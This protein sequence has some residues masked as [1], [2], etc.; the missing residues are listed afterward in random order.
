M[1]GGAVIR[2]RQLWPT[3]D[4][5]A[6]ARAGEID[7]VS[8]MRRHQEVV[9]LI[10]H[11]DWDQLRRMGSDWGDTFPRYARAHQV[12]RFVLGRI[13]AQGREDT[14]PERWID[15]LHEV[16]ERRR[17]REARLEAALPKVAGAFVKSGIG[18]RVLKGVPF[19]EKYFG[20]PGL[21]DSFDLDLLVREQDAH[22]A[23][24]TLIDLGYRAKRRRIRRSARGPEIRPH[25]LRTEHALELKR[26]AISVDLHWRLRTA[27]AYRIAESDVW[28]DPQ[29]VRVGGTGYPVLS[30]EYALV[31]LLISL[32]HDVGRR[33]ARLKHVLDVYQ[34]LRCLPDDFDWPGFFERRQAENTL[35]VAVNVLLLVRAVFGEEDDLPGLTAALDHHRSLQRPSSTAHATQL[36]HGVAGGW[37]N[38]RWLLSVYPVEWLRD[39]LWFVDR[40]VVHPGSLLVLPYRGLLFTGRVVGRRVKRYFSRGP[41]PSRGTNR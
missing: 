15:G 8:H 21:R 3:E 7:L 25:R 14:V 18:F 2:P 17:N 27:P 13:V 29:Q 26:G 10:A 28:S 1:L 35:S 38:I 11:D 33:G 39:A 4:L 22:D 34:L 30:D 19:S 37:L 23:V 41:S 36:I 9:R 24:R 5:L 20:G 31:L 16:T 6:A 32:A 40:H 12:A